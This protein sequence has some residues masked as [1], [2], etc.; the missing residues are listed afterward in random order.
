MSDTPVRRIIY[1]IEFIVAQGYLTLSDDEYPVLSTNAQ[2]ATV[3]HAE[4]HII[5]KLPREKEVSV[6][7]R[8]KAVLLGNSALF[9]ELVALRLTLAKESKVPAYVVFSDASLR[10]ICQKMPLSD[11]EFLD[12][13]GVGQAKL[14]KYG[15]AFMQVIRNFTERGN[16]DEY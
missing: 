2:S 10:D 6:S 11:K 13:S 1:T 8:K 9:D 16:E 15:D 4:T 12:V 7:K 14:N 3:L 5:M